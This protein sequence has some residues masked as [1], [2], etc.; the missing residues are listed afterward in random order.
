MFDWDSTLHFAYGASSTAAIK[1]VL[2]KMG[3]NPKKTI[4]YSAGASFAI[5]CAKEAN[6]LFRIVTLG[7][8]PLISQL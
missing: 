8:I 7:D 6:D 4:Y 3:L 5:G 2:D 1:Y